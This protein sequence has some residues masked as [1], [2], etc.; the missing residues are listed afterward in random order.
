M[1]LSVDPMLDRY[2]NLSPFQY[3]R[4][5]P[6]L[7]VDPNG[8]TDYEFDKKSGK[9]ILIEGTENSGPDR[10]IKNARYD[11]NGNLKNKSGVLQLEGKVEDYHDGFGQD[12]E[13]RFQFQTFTFS[14]ES[15]A[16]N[17]YAFMANSTNVEIGKWKLETQD[18]NR[19]TRFFTSGD[20]DK[21]RGE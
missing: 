1:W 14:N 4:N 2:P 9:L 16:E 18:G 21:I 20:K 11:E 3:C 13:G 19:Q 6:V 15:D 10:I 8:L 7:R 5:N 12:N 17:A